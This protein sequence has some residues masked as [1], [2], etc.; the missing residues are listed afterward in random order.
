MH[1]TS[2]FTVATSLLLVNAAPPPLTGNYIERI[3][4]YADFSVDPCD[5]F[6]A[7]SCGG[8]D[9]THPATLQT[10]SRS[11]FEKVWKSNKQFLS[12]YFGNFKGTD[13]I[14]T[15]LKQA[16][17]AC[18]L[19]NKD[20][21]EKAFSTILK[22]IDSNDFTTVQGRT[23]IMTELLKHSSPW[24]IG[25]DISTAFDREDKLNEWNLV[26]P[27]VRLYYKNLYTDE[28]LAIVT[29]SFN[30]LAKELPSLSIKQE[31][32]RALVQFENEITKMTAPWDELKL[33]AKYNTRF[34][35]DD[36]QKLLPEFVDW[37]TLF[38]NINN[39]QDPNSILVQNESYLQNL[40]E[41]LR[42]TD[43]N[44]VKNYLK[45]SFVAEFADFLH[46]EARA[47]IKEIRMKVLKSPPQGQKE[48]QCAL[49]ANSVFPVM[50]SYK[51][52]PTHLPPQKKE[53]AVEIVNAVQKSVE[54]L[55]SKTPWIQ[56]STRSA[57][58]EKLKALDSSRIGYPDFYL[59]ANEVMKYY[60]GLKITDNIA[61]I[62]LER[63]KNKFTK[64]VRQIGKNEDPNNW[65]KIETIEE[66][67]GYYVSFA[68][69]VSLSKGRILRTVC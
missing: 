61:E 3:L 46:D 68:F 5:D 10:G 8:F 19:R 62:G 31:D 65:G 56:P 48:E 35:L 38:A 30:T 52:I 63:S 40:A 24:L 39:G 12:E 1:I 4:S 58:L 64:T 28:N 18:M 11:N 55:L 13:S 51:F 54:K 34:S 23:V 57:A 15:S 47:P 45:L 2:L 14:D 29:E 7:F 22:L 43:S 20:S 26:Q 42:K 41:L 44:I 17:D 60:E 69:F 37:K 9:K 67:N 25:L 53:K 33:Q 36:L 66:V 49:L 27:P 32:V 6:Y 50:V 16:Y 21:S 59:D